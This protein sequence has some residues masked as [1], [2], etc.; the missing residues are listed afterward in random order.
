MIVVAAV[1]IV[2]SKRM[3]SCQLGL[4]RSA[5]MIWDVVYS[6]ARMSDGG[7]SSVSY[8]VPLMSWSCVNEPST[9]AT[10]GRV[11][12]AAS[13]AKDENGFVCPDEVVKMR[14]NGRS[15]K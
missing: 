5:V 2:V 10:C 12:A 13:A 15:V 7:C 1:L 3:E 4:L 6:P 11:P 14:E 8:M 9:N